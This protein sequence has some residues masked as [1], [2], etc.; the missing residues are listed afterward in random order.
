[1]PELSSTQHMR[2]V[3]LEAAG[4]IAESGMPTSGLLSRAYQCETYL[5]SGRIRTGPRWMTATEVGFDGVSVLVEAEELDVD[6][7]AAVGQAV[8][9]VLA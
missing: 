5:V 3:A 2:C 6:Q 1:M 9:A 4:R 8:K 7:A